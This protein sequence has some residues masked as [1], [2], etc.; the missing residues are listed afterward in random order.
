MLVLEEKLTENPQRREDLVARAKRSVKK[1]T[2]RRM[3][4]MAFQGQT[5]EGSNGHEIFISVNSIETGQRRV[6]RVESVGG[7]YPSSVL[8]LR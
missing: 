4:L 2:Q 3:L 8:D 5:E 6:S 7:T 1:E